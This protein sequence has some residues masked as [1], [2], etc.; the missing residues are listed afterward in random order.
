[1]ERPGDLFEVR[2]GWGG[3]TGRGGAGCQG[4]RLRGTQSMT[5]CGEGGW[6]GWVFGLVGDG[7]DGGVTK[8]DREPLDL[9]LRLSGVA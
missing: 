3:L 9:C 8:R 2:W 7:V 1:M 6:D 4:G 5:G